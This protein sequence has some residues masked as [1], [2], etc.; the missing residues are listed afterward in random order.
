M[1]LA[2]LAVALPLA[3]SAVAWGEP[4]K[5][6][7]SDATSPAGEITGV[8]AERG[9]DALA[10]AV[11]GAAGAP[12]TQF[13]L[14]VDGDPSTGYALDGLGADAM[15]EGTGVF[16]HKGDPALW[17]WDQTGTAGRSVSG[18][19]ATYLFDAPAG[20]PAKLRMAVLTRSA[21]YATLLDRC[22]DVGGMP[23]TTVAAS[24]IATSSPATSPPAATRP[25]AGATPGAAPDVAMAA[26]KADRD[27][28]ARQRFADAKSFVTFYRGGR[29]AEL[30]HSDV[31]ILH[32]PQMSPPEVKQL[33]AL[34]V[35]TVGYISIGEDDVV[36]DGDG[37]GPGGKASWYF[38]RDADGHPDMNGNWGSVFADAADPKW[39]ANRV[40]R[41]TG[42]VREYGFDGIFLDTIDT[43]QLYPESAA[44]MTQLIK[45]LRDALPDKV[46]VLNQGW[47]VLPDVAQYGDG[48]MLEGFTAIW[49][50]EN[51]RYAMN[52]PQSL[53][54]H[55]RRVNGLLKDVREKHPLKVLVLDYAERDDR[56]SQQAAADRAVSF[57]FLFSASTLMIDDIYPPVQ[58][59]A[60]PALLEL[61][62]TPEQMSYALPA[63]ANGFPAGTTL[64]PS[65]TFAGYT[66]EPLVDGT[67]L[68]DRGELAWNRRAWASGEDG[69]AAWLE[70]RLPEARPGGGK[71]RIFWNDENGLSPSR[72]VRVESAE[73]D[74][75]WTTAWQIEGND[76]RQSAAVLPDRPY[77]R[78]RIV[79]EPGGGSDQRPDLMWI[80]QLRLDD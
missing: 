50:F 71:L 17:T 8:T 11:A 29:L 63:A 54:Y 24:S 27:L 65:G 26:P 72:D 70:I 12:V 73:G 19:V 45:E 30:S 52:T 41:A 40:A 67:D 6:S 3:A 18:D 74:G 35:V 33:G 51:K 75:E 34:G 39:R 62:A 4:V 68:R 32:T 60:D 21:D 25:A 38:D 42:M 28:P 59:K 48:I 31:A 1:R 56:A 23:F 69:A 78:L 66:V 55:T 80:A 61:K 9:G 10:V 64:V 20:D 79:Q 16:R 58:G 44:G 77:D 76:A 36:H 43:A 22:P 14:D 37:T 46:I 53:D 2:P 57:G 5:D 7:P 13:L 47:A 15:V 49:D